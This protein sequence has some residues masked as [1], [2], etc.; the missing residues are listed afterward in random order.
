MSGLEPPTSLDWLPAYSNQ[1][2]YTAP[3]L[4]FYVATLVAILIVYPTIPAAP[5]CP[6]S[7]HFHVPT[8]YTLALWYRHFPSFLD[9]VCYGGVCVKLSKSVEGGGF[10][11]PAAFSFLIV[12][13]ADSNRRSSKASG[14]TAE[15]RCARLLTIPLIPIRLHHLP[16]FCPM[17]RAPHGGR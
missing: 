12:G 14:T 15:R 8:Q 13:R 17:S 2:N 11:P 4:V 6:W 5:G 9:A 16:A 3:F 7:P 1:L 10:G